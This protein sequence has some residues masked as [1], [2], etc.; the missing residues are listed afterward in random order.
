MKRSL[1][2]PT[3]AL[4]PLA[5]AIAAALG[6]A[7]LVMRFFLYY[8]MMQLFSLCAVD[9]FRNA[10]AREPGLRRVDR[11]FGAS[12]LPLLAA[13]GLALGL[14]VPSFDHVQQGMLNLLPV[15]IAA[16]CTIIEQLFEERMHAV[17]KGMD[18]VLMQAVSALLLLSGLMI[19]SSGSV[20]ASVPGFYTLCASA[21]GML[22][23]AAVSLVTEPL[24]AFSIAPRNLGF[25]PK[26]MAQCLLYPAGM[27]VLVWLGTWLDDSFTKT[28]IEVFGAPWFLLGFA[29]W[30]MSRTVCR[31]AQDES[32]ALNLLLVAVCAALAVPAAW[33]P[34]FGDFAAAAWIALLCAVIVFCA[35]GW[36]LYAGVVLL[37]A[38]MYFAGSGEPHMVVPMICAAAAVV[39]NLHK[40]FLRKV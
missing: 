19:D 5:G 39:L 18:L 37:W 3:A 13:L 24:R 17:G 25:C 1:M 11:R 22:I 21:L 23:A 29:L 32:R 36:R 20:P 15:C 9:C 33:M 28:A 6:D 2:R 26:A 40:A 31:R 4:F 30:R 34:G 38:A 8:F 7:A 14:T 12:V 10:A 16:W 35:P 27:A